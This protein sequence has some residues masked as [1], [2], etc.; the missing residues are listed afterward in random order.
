MGYE[1]E[2]ND[3]MRYATM[4][5]MWHDMTANA[6]TQKLMLTIYEVLAFLFERDRERRRRKKRAASEV[7]KRKVLSLE[8]DREEKHSNNIHIDSIVAIA[9]ASMECVDHNDSSDCCKM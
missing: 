3:R 1:N 7:L 9:I 5:L 8:L 2:A 6:C 4:V